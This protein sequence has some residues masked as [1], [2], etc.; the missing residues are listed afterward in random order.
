MTTKRNLA[1]VHVLYEHVHQDRLDILIKNK[2]MDSQLLKKLIAYKSQFVDDKTGIRIEYVYSKETWD[3]SGRLYC[4]GGVGLQSF[5]KDVRA[6]LTENIYA[7]FDLKNSAPSILLNLTKEASGE[8]EPLAKYVADR[9][10]ILKKLK[11]NKDDVLSVLFN[12]NYSGDNLFLKSLHQKLYKTLV[13]IFKE[14]D[15][16]KECL[17]KSKKNKGNPD[18]SFLSNVYQTAENKILRHMVQ[19]FK[20]KGFEVGSL[21]FD[22]LLIKRAFDDIPMDDALEECN[23]YLLEKTGYDISLVEKSMKYDPSFLGNAIVKSDKGKKRDADEMEEKNDLNI[24]GYETF[25]WDRLFTPTLKNLAEWFVEKRHGSVLK[26]P[27]D[28]MFILRKDNT[29]QMCQ[30]IRNSDMNLQIGDCLTLGFKE[31]LEAFERH[32]DKDPEKVFV[33]SMRKKFKIAVEGRDSIGIAENVTRM[34]GSDEKNSDLFLSKPHLLAFTNGVYDLNK[35]E[36]RREVQPDD[37][38]MKTTGYDFPEKPARRE[39]REKILNFLQDIYGSDEEAIF[40]LLLLARALYGEVVEEMFLIHKGEGR[41]GKGVLFTLIAVTFG[42]Y[43]YSIGSENITR[44]SG[45]VDK[46]NSQMFN[47]FGCRMLSTSEP[48]HKEKILSSFIKLI[49]GNDPMPTRTLNGKPISFRVTGLFNILTNGTPIF[50]AVG[51]AVGLRDRT[52]EYP[53]IYENIQKGEELD[54]NCKQADEN[55]KELFRSDE[56]RDAFMQILLETYRDNF[57]TSKKIIAPKRVV[58]YTNKYLIHN[59]P[60]SKWFF[61]SYKYTGNPN[62]K[63]LRSKVY[64]LYKMDH[65]LCPEDKSFGLKSFHSELGVALGGA[66]KCKGLFYYVGIREIQEDDLSEVVML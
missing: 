8:N 41:N 25:D 13:P 46:P 63:I 43:F 49:T 12:S 52:I 33:P 62:D 24:P 1:T 32:S 61:K 15:E 47:V 51:K 39:V 54:Q 4:R 42:G 57:L 9:P 6:Y 19:F 16:F 40:I 34:C 21:I 44:T 26:H 56:Y 31:I 50:D 5:P 17:E 11:L 48:P 3:N 65:S 64:D 7:D 10:A 53:F 18:G 66:R 37:Y 58:D 22:G 59:L 27:S 20:S 60:F 30:N 36:F 2:M 23:S 29:W 35:Q 55:I 38:I 45:G 14:N 28:V